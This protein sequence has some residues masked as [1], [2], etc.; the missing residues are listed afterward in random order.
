MEYYTKKEIGYIQELD[1][2]YA[3]SAQKVIIFFKEL[4][5]GELT[6]VITETLKENIHISK[7]RRHSVP[8]IWKVLVK[9][10]NHPKYNEIMEIG[11]FSVES[12]KWVQ[13]M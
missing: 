8:K 2:I 12:I 7:E 10:L 6:G 1:N 3:G 13:N 9:D 5:K 11:C 4:E